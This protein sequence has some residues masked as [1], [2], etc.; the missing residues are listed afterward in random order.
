MVT[1]YLNAWAIG[2][3]VWF[4]AGGMAAYVLGKLLKGSGDGDDN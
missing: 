4:V 3:I 2:F 1:E